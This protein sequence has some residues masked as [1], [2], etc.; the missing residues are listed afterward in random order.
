MSSSLPDSGG[1]FRRAVYLLLIVTTTAAMVGRVL[2]VKSK[3][4]RTPTPFLS[5][6]D[7]SRWCTI[8]ALV[9]ERTYAIDRVTQERGWNTIDKVKHKDRRGRLRSYSSKPPLFP[10][11]LAAQYWAIKQTTGQTLAENPFFVGRTI[12]LVT[13]VIP[14]VIY[15]VLLAGRVERL[16]TSDW[17]RAYVMAAA[18]WGTFL[19][20][21][22]VTINNH[23]P[24]AISVLIA[25]CAALPI[26]N[27]GERRLRYFVVAGLFA[28]FAAANELPAL[29]FLAMLGAALLWKSPRGTL[30]AFVPA[31]LIVTGA[32]FAT[33][34]AAHDS[35]RPPYA[36]REEGSNWY[37]YE[38]SYWTEEGRKGID[39]GTPS[40][41][42]Y[43]FHV[44]VG[45]HGIFSLTPIWLLSAAGVVWLVLGPRHPLRGLALMA[46]T[47]TL[48]CLAFYVARPLVDRNYG[49]M[50][51]GFRWMFWFTPLW[52]LTMIPAADWIAQKRGWPVAVAILLLAISALSAG[53]ASLN[54]WTLPW[55]LQ[56]YLDW[57]GQTL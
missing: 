33:N 17:G 41:A 18:T 57:T 42:V 37:E 38:G 9:D 24:A 52:L 26:W 7:R 46:G 50:T 5:A 48:V 43:A 1:P 44:V 20:T 51:A 27:N 15:F 16:G 34:Y 47:L 21:F 13:N 2:T 28:A 56:F 31:A 45:H 22:S 11:L 6:N 36:H 30:L 49:G 54:P 10:T 3:S 23:L 35:W 55:I 32:F 14:L 4:D 29:G 53:Y 19:T 8:R 25:V 12:I 40:R 39:R